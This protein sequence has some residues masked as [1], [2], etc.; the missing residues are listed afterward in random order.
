MSCSVTVTAPSGAPAPSGTVTVTP[1]NETCDISTDP[2]DVTVPT[3]STVGAQETV[4]ASFPG[5]SGLG[6][7]T[8]STA[9]TL[10]LRPTAIAM[11]CATDGQNEGVAV[12]GEEII[13]TLTVSDLYDPDA[14]TP[15]GTVQATAGADTEQCSL[16]PESQS[17]MVFFTS[18]LTSPASITSSYA[19]D[20]AE[21][22][23]S[24]GSE[25]ISVV[26]PG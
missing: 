3:S 12:S 24:T 2:C 18:G 23:A 9:V 6:S 21:F 22:A 5:Q 15:G 13:C 20:G 26:A 17:C 16:N 8:G 4:S 11:Q 7:S 10:T 25:A 19:G 1:G 14:F